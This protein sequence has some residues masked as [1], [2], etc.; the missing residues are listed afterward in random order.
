M[1]KLNILYPIP[2][3]EGCYF[4]D[5][6]GNT[7]SNHKGEFKKITWIN[8]GGYLYFSLW[9]KLK[10]K[11]IKII[12]LHRTLATMFIHNDDPINKTDVDHINGRPLDNRLEN[13]RWVT[14]RQNMINRDVKGT[15]SYHKAHNY[16]SAFY[17]IYVKETE[18]I[19]T[20]CKH[21]KTKEEAEAQLKQ[22][23]NDYPR[24]GVIF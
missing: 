20:L 16:W 23:R 9:N 24:R 3:G 4:I 11:V 19:K 13:L 17:R 7:Y 15:V 21:F 5:K 6:E 1:S 12:T 10:K 14:K 22:W 8:K 18:K 2:D